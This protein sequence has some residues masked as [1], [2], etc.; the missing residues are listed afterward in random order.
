MTKNYKPTLVVIDIQKE[1]VTPGRPFFL[2]GIA[3]SLSNARALL[4]HARQQ[5]W[6][7]VHVQHLQEG[8]L[9]NVAEEYSDFVE[10]FAPQ[11]G[12]TLIVKN[13]LSAFTSP[14]FV[15]ALGEPEADVYVIGYGST[16]CCMATIVDAALFG[17]KFTLIHDASWA[18]VPNPSFEEAEMHRHA[19]AILGI[20]GQ[21]QTTEHVLQ[22]LA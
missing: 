4:E 14:E 8:P 12:E 2:T 11:N 17:R 15:K 1:Y 21:L 19:T 6:P 3:P 9:F 20:H 22:R 5:G 18:R 13:K 10:G 7:V 16:M